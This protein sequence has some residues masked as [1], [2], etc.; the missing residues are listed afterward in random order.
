MVVHNFCHYVTLGKHIFAKTV[1]KINKTDDFFSVKLMFFADTSCHSRE[2]I[3]KKEIFR[4]L[5][6]A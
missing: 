4:D 2:V 1:I 3:K 5:S 6:L